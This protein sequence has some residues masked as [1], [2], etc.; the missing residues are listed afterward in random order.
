VRV[1]TGYEHRRLSIEMIALI[2]VVFLL[3][4]FFIY[5]MLSMAVE[6]SLDVNLPDAQGRAGEQGIVI[7][8]DKDNRMLLEGESLPMDRL[9]DQVSRRAAQGGFPVIIRGDRAAHLGTAVELL[10]SLRLRGVK[11]ISFLTQKRGPGE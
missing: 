5:V 8:I 9:V 6:N 7:T 1:K 4:V 3:L 10:A 11:R 2:D